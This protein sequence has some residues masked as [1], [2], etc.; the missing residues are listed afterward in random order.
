MAVAQTELMDSYKRRS[1][2]HTLRFKL[3]VDLK[4]HSKTAGL[5]EGR[6]VGISASGTS[7]M[8][9]LELSMGEVVE[10]DFELPF[11]PAGVPAIVRA[12]NAFRDRFQFVQPH[13]AESRIKQSCAMLAP[14]DRHPR[15]ALAM[16]IQAAPSDRS[17]RAAVD[18]GFPRAYHTPTFLSDFFVAS[19]L[20]KGHGHTF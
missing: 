1:G 13:A 15:Q 11:G 12:R 4:I 19:P 18:L 14:P 3:D 2:R 5:I 7:A 9:L 10:L 16:V 17:I 8:L 6:T 20:A